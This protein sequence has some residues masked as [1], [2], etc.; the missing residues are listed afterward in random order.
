MIGRVYSMEGVVKIGQMYNIGVCAENNMCRQDPLAQLR[1][2]AYRQARP[3]LTRHGM[4][5][6][7]HLIGV[8]GADTARDQGA[9][10][11]PR[12]WHVSC[13]GSDGDR[14]ARPTRETDLTQHGSRRAQPCRRRTPQ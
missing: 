10:R 4:A 5:R 1:P 13:I 12:V 7:L 3:D 11:K 9:A 2:D 8:S 14:A 6:D